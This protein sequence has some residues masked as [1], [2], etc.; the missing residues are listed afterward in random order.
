[1]T[2]A[3]RG[4][5]LALAAAWLVALGGPALRAQSAADIAVP[6]PT[7]TA[8]APVPTTLDDVWIAPTGKP[9][10]SMQ[11]LARA[12]RLLAD[13]HAAEA[14]PL[15]R[16]AS[17]GG[18]PLA[19]YQRYYTGLVAF[20]LG[21][22]D[23]AREALD[24]LVADGPHWYL[25]DGARQLAGAVAEAQNDFGAAAKYYEPLTHRTTLAPDDA[26][27]RLARVRQAL[28]DGQGAAEAY[29]HVYYEFPLSDLANAAAAQIDALHA[30]EPLTADSGRYRLELG[31]AERLFGSRRYGEARDGFSALAPLASGDDRERVSL[32]LAECD[33]YLKRY[34]AARDALEPWTSSAHRRAEARFFH[35]S[36]LRGLKDDTEYQRLARAL[37][38]DF[39]TDSWAEETLNNLGSHYIIGDEDVK[40]DAVFR[41][42]AARFPDGRY[43]QR[44][45]WKI[46]W[47]AYRT[48]QWDEC[49]REFEQAAT[50]FPRADYRPSWLYWAARSREQLS[51]T[52][53]ADRLYGVLVADYVNSVL[54]PAGHA[55]AHRAPRGADEPRGRRRHDLRCGARRDRRGRAGRLPECRSRP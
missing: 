19:D 22:L 38:D 18:T 54:R 4:P 7:A 25:A 10:A 26:W 42:L 12:V 20:R 8:H 46:G 17:L 36:S 3:A 15:V 28:G 52:A 6:L 14:A 23:A 2:R 33:Y 1:M 34:Q 21:K 40:A 43:A 50:R 47:N 48:G 44:A 24:A 9:G 55:T 30:W 31:R 51:D 5:A 53:A 32:R 37:V 41:E 13:D 39:P 45:L 11:A 27:S 16:K 49:A 35:L 29:A